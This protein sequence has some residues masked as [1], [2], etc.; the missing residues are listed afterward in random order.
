MGDTHYELYI[1]AYT[2]ET[3]PLARLSEYLAG[4]A[5][6]LGNESH[7]HFEAVAAGSLR[8]L[9]SVDPIAEPKVRGRMDEIR[10]GKGPKPALAAFQTIDDL[11]AA[12]GAIGRI[13]RGGSPV[14]EFPGRHRHVDEL[15]GPVEQA[16]SLDG[17]IIQIG[18]RDETVNVHLKSGGDVVR[19]VT[20]KPVAKAL[21]KHIFGGPVRVRGTGTWA[22][23]ESG[24]W[25]IKRFVIADFDVLDETPLSRLFSGLRDQL[26]PPANGRQNPAAMVGELRAE[27]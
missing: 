14:V 15:V 13:S 1:D 2:P 24:G 9:A 23:R 21:A 18:G 10:F 19:C 22:R 7:V 8:L 25:E 3:I 4:F 6:L 17:E 26:T 12:D 11:L 16:G 5:G 27:D 20:S